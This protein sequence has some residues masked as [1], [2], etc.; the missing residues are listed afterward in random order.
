MELS[1]PRKR[2]QIPTLMLS[3]WLLPVGSALGYVQPEAPTDKG[4]TPPLMFKEQVLRP[5]TEKDTESKFSSTGAS[6]VERDKISGETRLLS[7]RI[8]LNVGFDFSAASLEAAC[9]S[10]ID[11]NPEIFGVSSKDLTLRKSSLYFG[12]EEQFLKFSVSR[13]GLDVFD[14]SI[15]FRFK[16]G[17]LVQIANHSFF[18]AKLSSSQERADLDDI[19]GTET[20]AEF[21]DKGKFLYRVRATKDAYEL[22][23]VKEYNIQTYL[24]QRVS[25]QLEADS[26]DVFQL[27]NKDYHLS[28]AQADLHPRWHNESLET[29]P[30]PYLKISTNGGSK[31]SD[32]SGKFDYSER[33]A[34]SI[35]GLHGSYVDIVPKSGGKIS[36]TAIA[37]DSGWL[38]DLTKPG[39]DSPWI[40][41]FIAQTMVY[42]HT[43]LMIS[44]AKEYISH[45]WLNST[46]TANVNLT[47]TCNAHWDGS[48]INFYSGNSQCANTG[49]IAD[50]V[51]HEWGHGLD[52]KTGGIADGAYSE[53]FGDIMSLIMTGSSKLGI[54]FRLPSNEPVRDLEPDKVY[55]DDRG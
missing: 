30:L 28:K 4:F 9:L 13:D 7:G 43:N 51:Y 46:L 53:G 14:A 21:I 15:D 1:T 37:G 3:L 22:V 49:I 36:K 39:N 27:K 32:A 41:K 20:G 18:E 31:Y 19:A 54:G 2:K 33:Q 26:G 8:P 44:K 50:V 11:E 34:P 5:S 55:P 25:I 29:K 6:Y 24:G 45:S 16:N 38:I 12:K 17:H 35:N 42:Y 23:K 48:T 10:Y 52:A 40:D 47:R